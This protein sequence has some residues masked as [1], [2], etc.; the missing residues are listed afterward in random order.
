M[1]QLMT[2]FRDPADTAWNYM[3]PLATTKQYLRMVPA[4]D[5]NYECVV[6]DGLP[7]KVLSNSDDPPN[8]YHTKDTFVP[9]PTIPD[10]WK[11]LG[12]LDDRLTL[13]NGEKVL[14]V[15][16]EHFIRQ[17]ELV[18]ESVV[19]GIGKAVPGLLIVP[20]HHAA[21]MTKEDLMQR[22]QPDIEAANSRTEAFGR[23]LP[24]MVRILDVGTSYPRTDKGTI[25]RA[26]FY[27][28]F[29]SLIEEIY[30]AFDSP[31]VG[32]QSGELVV[33]DKP[34]L[35]ETLLELVQNELHSPDFEA[36]T[37]FFAAGMDSL[38]AIALRAKILKRIN[39]GSKTLGQNLIF[40]YPSVDVL[41]DHLVALRTD[42]TTSV[43]S[44]EDLMN[45]LIAKYSVFAPR[46]DGTIEPDGETLVSLS[47]PYSVISRKSN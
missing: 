19:F 32:T 35:V 13:V 7:S 38:H 5:G 4:G 27:R 46:V 20:S 28:E 34:E 10:A 44:E 42:V 26:R 17:N 47:S 11:Y 33:L 30:K 21:G 9:H 36:S 2:S 15:P 41:A 18:E 22:L 24:E 1:G 6:L 43:K 23:I 14:P 39:V 45:D 37:D 25:I 12:R 16:Y 29:S 40:E 31:E 3:R 8:S